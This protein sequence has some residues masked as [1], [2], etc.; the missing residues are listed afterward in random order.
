MPRYKGDKYRWKGVTDCT[1]HAK[2]YPQMEYNTRVCLDLFLTADRKKV[3]VEER[4]WIHTPEQP[5]DKENGDIYCG[6]ITRRD[7]KTGAVELMVLQELDRRENPWRYAEWHFFIVNVRK[8]RITEIPRYLPI[9][10]KRW[11]PVAMELPNLTRIDAKVRAYCASAQA[12]VEFNKHPEKQ[13][14]T[15]Q[16]GD[17]FI[18]VRGH[19]YYGDLPGVESK[20]NGNSS[21]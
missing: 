16:V 4:E 21:S 6:E 15:V 5:T 14:L 7:I 17:V 1:Y 9:N 11:I 18:L 10:D 13:E 12:L 19:G 2:M 8:K 20:Q 3:Y